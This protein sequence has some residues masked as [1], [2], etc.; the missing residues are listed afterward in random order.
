M[1]RLSAPSK[2]VFDSPKEA[3]GGAEAEEGLKTLAN[4]K[5]PSVGRSRLLEV[6]SQV[7]LKT[8]IRTRVQAEGLLETV[9]NTLI[10]LYLIGIKTMHKGLQSNCGLMLSLL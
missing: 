10:E 9:I 8:I 2:G 6:G 5:R 1:G 3:V 7:P 4:C